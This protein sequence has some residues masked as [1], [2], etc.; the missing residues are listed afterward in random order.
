[1]PVIQPTD[2]MELRRKEDLSVNA[3]VLHRR[4]NRMIAGPG[5]KR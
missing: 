3:S 1:M 5:R 2:D 4:G